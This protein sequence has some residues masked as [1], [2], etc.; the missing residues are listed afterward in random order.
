MKMLKLYATI[1]YSYFLIR[2]TISKQQCHR[3]K[4]FAKGIKSKLEGVDEYP[5]FVDC[6]KLDD[7]PARQKCFL[8]S[9]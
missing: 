7:K 2:V 4:N 1:Y 6:D 9:N 8:S 3:K 5:S